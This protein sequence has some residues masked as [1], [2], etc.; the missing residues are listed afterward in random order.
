MQVIKKEH[1]R[2]GVNGQVE[3]SA[4]GQEK[5]PP[6]GVISVTCPMSWFPLWVMSRQAGMESLS[7]SN[8][9]GEW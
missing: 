7:S 8:S 4:G 2:R 6:L 3:V 1:S 9:I 5:S